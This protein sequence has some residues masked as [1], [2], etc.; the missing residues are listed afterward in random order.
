MKTYSKTCFSH[1]FICSYENNT[2][3]NTF[4]LETNIKDDYKYFFLFKM[5]QTVP[6]PDSRYESKTFWKWDPQPLC[7]VTVGNKRRI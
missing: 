3:F 7:T 6:Q 5:G 1:F 4:T 2:H